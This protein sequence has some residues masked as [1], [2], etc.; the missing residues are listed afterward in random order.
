MQATECISESCMLQR[1]EGERVSKLLQA[2][3]PAPGR[4]LHQGAEPESRA[5]LASVKTKRL[6]SQVLRVSHL[7]KAAWRL[8]T[9]SSYGQGQR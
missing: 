4:G 8:Q 7:F 9:V 1:R 2:R 6:S 3:L 5:S